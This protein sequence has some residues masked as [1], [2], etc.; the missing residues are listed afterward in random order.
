LTN[1][2]KLKP[3]KFVCTLPI[4]KSGERFNVIADSAFISGSIRSFE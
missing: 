4:F 3:G 2:Q 1:L